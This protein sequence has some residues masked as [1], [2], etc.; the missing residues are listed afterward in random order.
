[1]GWRR[2]QHLP[3]LAGQE[4][5]GWRSVGHIAS[6]NA[7]RAYGFLQCDEPRPDV[8]FHR[9][10]LP[11]EVQERHGRDLVGKRCE[12]T[13]TTT[14]DGKDRADRIW[15]LEGLD[16][17]NRRRGAI[18]ARH[19]PEAVAVRRQRAGAPPEGPPPPDLDADQVEAMTQFLEE[20][21][22]VMDYGRFSNHFAGL[23]KAQLEP[24]FD[25]IPEVAGQGG[26]RWQI[27]LKGVQALTPEERTEREALERQTQNED[28]SN[29]HVEE[30]EV[31]VDE[32]MVL[33][34]S[35]SLRLMGVM[36]DWNQRTASG[37]A[38]AEGYEDIVVEEAALPS[39]VQGRKDLDLQGC[40]LT[41]EMVTADDGALVARDVHL[42]LQSDGEGGW[43]FR[44]I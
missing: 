35:A 32:P 36:R 14:K 1:M 43:I 10:L 40:E 11:P 20:K 21:G 31:E 12:F 22:G 13:F 9:N 18:P 2:P 5:P 17:G 19:E 30:E 26:G 3:A 38:F 28:K 42:L 37:T 16:A 39:E 15:L 27:M 29:G 44:R 7:D 6:Y 8:Y 4:A 24:H 41:L 23:K 25:L 33:E 34:P